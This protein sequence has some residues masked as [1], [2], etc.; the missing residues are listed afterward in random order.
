MQVGFGARAV[1]VSTILEVVTICH[2]WRVYG[3]I[4]WKIFSF[5]QY[6]S[7][8]PITYGI[9]IW[10][11]ACLVTSYVYRLEVYVGKDNT[12][13]KSRTLAMQIGMAGQVVSQ[14]T[15]GLDGHWY[16]IICDNNFTLQ[17][18]FL[19][20]CWLVGSMWWELHKN[21]EKASLKT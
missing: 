17:R 14:L 6:L 1:S 18:I 19:I 21:N 15:Q 2:H 4:Q 11:M 13:S 16:T 3:G 10:A 5:K 9:K 8:K 20:T 12:H 7:T